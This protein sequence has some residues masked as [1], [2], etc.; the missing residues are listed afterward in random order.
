MNI[1]VIADE[2]ALSLGREKGVIFMGLLSSGKIE[3]CRFD[4]IL[5]RFKSEISFLSGNLL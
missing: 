2:E 3:G 5:R 1:L 4:F